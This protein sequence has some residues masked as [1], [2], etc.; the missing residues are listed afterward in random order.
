MG[1]TRA[2]LSKS[3]RSASYTDG[4]GKSISIYDDAAAEEV[5]AAIHAAAKRGGGAFQIGNGPVQ[6]YEDLAVM[7]T[8][9][10]GSA[11]YTWDKTGDRV[12][13]DRVLVSRDLEGNLTR[14]KV[15]T[16]YKTYGS[17]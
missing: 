17:D 4:T 8:T 1:M 16:V 2:E 12:K 9:K 6:W 11:V 3:L 5:E 10:T 15:G 7:D 14:E 13:H